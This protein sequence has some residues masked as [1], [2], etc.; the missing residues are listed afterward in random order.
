MTF[1]ETSNPGRSKVPLYSSPTGFK[2]KTKYPR[3]TTT[4]PEMI[5]KEEDEV[6]FINVFVDHAEKDKKL[7]ER[8]D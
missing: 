4:K 7:V 1:I 6:W 3:T 2:N 8:G 5:V